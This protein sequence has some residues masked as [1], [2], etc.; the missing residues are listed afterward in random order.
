MKTTTAIIIPNRKFME[1][2]GTAPYRSNNTTN[3]DRNMNVPIR[4]REKA[5]PVPVVLALVG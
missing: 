4:L 5:A 3:V 1:N 2:T